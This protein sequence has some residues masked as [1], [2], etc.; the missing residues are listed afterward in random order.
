MKLTSLDREE[1][2][3]CTPTGTQW[4]SRRRAKALCAD[5]RVRTFVCGVPDTLFAI[6]CHG[7]IAKKNRWWDSCLSG[8]MRT[9]SRS[10]SLRKSE[11]RGLTASS[12]L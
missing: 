11:R 3:C 8:T 6:P 1:L 12:D 10:C 7:K 4:G 2:A 5:G 9:G